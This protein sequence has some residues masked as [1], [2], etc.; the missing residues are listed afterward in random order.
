MFIIIQCQNKIKILKQRK[1]CTSLVHICTQTPTYDIKYI[2]YNSDHI[3]LN[4]WVLLIT[5]DIISLVYNSCWGLLSSLP[6]LSRY[7]WLN[8]NRFLRS[9][10]WYQSIQEVQSSQGLIWSCTVISVSLVIYAL[11]TSRQCHLIGRYIGGQIDFC[12]SACSISCI[13]LV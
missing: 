3:S 11:S 9:W 10:G 7:S 13:V 1:K 6:T 8:W 5:L 4:V 2:H 12:S